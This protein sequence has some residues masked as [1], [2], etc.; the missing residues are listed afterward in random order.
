MPPAYAEYASDTERGERRL[1]PA[2]RRSL[3]TLAAPGS[4]HVSHRAMPVVLPCTP[5]CCAPRCPDRYRRRL[6]V[7]TYATFRL[8]FLSSFASAVVTVIFRYF[9]AFRAMLVSLL[10][11]ALFSAMRASRASGSHAIFLSA[12]IDAR[13]V[14]ARTPGCYD[15]YGLFHA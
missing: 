1:Q 3:S 13:H 8:L 4:F 9:F 12:A 2:R 7:A 6:F 11:L 15:F 5:R 14:R 10:S